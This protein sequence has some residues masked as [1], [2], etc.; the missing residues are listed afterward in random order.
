M[1]DD[2]TAKEVSLMFRIDDMDPNGMLHNG[3]EM[4]QPEFFRLY[5]R[6]TGFRAEL[7]D[8]TV[9]VRE[10][11]SNT[12]GVNHTRLSTILG[13]YESETEGV[14]VSNSASVILSSVDEV[15]PDLLVRVLPDY[16]GQTRDVRRKREWYV[17]GAPELVVEVALSSRADDLHKKR[18]RYEHA[19]VCELIVFCLRPVKLYWFDLSSK[20][21]IHADSN[22]IYKSKVFPGLWISEKSLASKSYK[23]C[24]K[25]INKGIA[26][27]EHETFAKRLAA[28][29]VY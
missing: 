6:S 26:S 27:P 2:R 4:T 15:Q 29:K 28:S 5:S 22:G 7:I 3:D 12:H 21:E 1:C 18:L 11:L 8:G 17:G 19:G 20:T 16:Q 10:P 24:I 25:L 9:Y 23:E 14:Q 13:L